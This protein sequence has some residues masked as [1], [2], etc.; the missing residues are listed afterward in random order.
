MTVIVGVVADTHIPERAEGLHPRLLD[1][2]HAHDVK[3]ILHAGDIS[4]PRVLAELEQVAPVIAVRGNR[5]VLF[6]DLPLDR[7][8]TFAGHK[9]ALMHGHGGLANYLFTKLF[10]LAE[11]YRLDR[12][13]SALQKVEP[14]T[15]VI[16][17]AHTH[18]RE[19]FWRD[20]RLYFNPGS[21]AQNNSK[22]IEPSYGILHFEQGGEVT[23]EIVSLSGSRLT[24][25]RWAAV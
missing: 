13:W 19:N 24:G 25:R 4:T 15:R 20:G 23:G 17:F 9:V 10:Y 8:L 21:A 18:Q 5:D 16:V 22:E 7:T 12:Y 3:T 2:L 1:S 14:G 6:K 11:G